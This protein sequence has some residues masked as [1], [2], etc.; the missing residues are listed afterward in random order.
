MLKIDKSGTSGNMGSTNAGSAGGSGVF[1]KE[2]T[3]SQQLNKSLPLGS[4]A[5][6]K[7]GSTSFVGTS[8]AAMQA[9]GGPH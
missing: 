2:N 9:H 3:N 5:N 7:S 6:S 8:A 4:V 1:V